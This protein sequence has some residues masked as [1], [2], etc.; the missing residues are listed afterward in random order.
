MV[1]PIEQP[2]FALAPI[3][4]AKYPVCELIALRL[5]ESNPQPYPRPAYS[6]S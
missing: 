3:R 6:A 5:T 1:Q 2:E 4:G